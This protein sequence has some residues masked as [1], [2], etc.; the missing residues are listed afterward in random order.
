MPKNSKRGVE[1][2]V[3]VAMLAAA[4]AAGYF[5]YGKNGAKNRKKV[6]GWML[7]A[8]G[9]VLEQLERMKEVNQA[10][11][12]QAVEKVMARYRSM[13]AKEIAAL[14]KELKGYWAGIKRQAAPAGPEKKKKTARKK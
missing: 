12:R 1:V 3:G 10:T 5:L 13:D 2:G 11:Y 8:K 7:K 14:S 6:K 4:A 9:E